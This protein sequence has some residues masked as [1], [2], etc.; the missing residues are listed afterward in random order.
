MATTGSKA[1]NYEQ[2]KKELSPEEFHK[3]LEDN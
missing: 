3:I 2:T 1:G